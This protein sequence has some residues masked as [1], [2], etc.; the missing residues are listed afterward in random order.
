MKEGPLKELLSAIASATELEV[1]VATA[2]VGRETL[3]NFSGGN[4]Y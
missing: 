4:K 3:N 1:V 2:R